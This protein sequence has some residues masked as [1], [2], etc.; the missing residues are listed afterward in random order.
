[1]GSNAGVPLAEFAE[2]Y[3]AIVAAL[4]AAEI[5]VIL[6]TT[7]VIGEN[8]AGRANRLLKPY[9]AAIRDLAARENLRLVDINR[10]FHDAYD[11]AAAYKQEVT[12]TSDGL[13][14]NRQ[15]HALMARTIMT[16]LGLLK[17]A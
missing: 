8:P 7:S 10:A 16:E 2:R 3:T 15:G 13:H 5:T 6:L 11:R 1:A 14:P 12:L 9:N 4:R 17:R